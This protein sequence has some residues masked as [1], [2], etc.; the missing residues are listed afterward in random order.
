MKWYFLNTKARLRFALRYP[1]YVLR[2]TARE[3]TFADERFLAALTGNHAAQIR[4]FLHEPFN[5]PSFLAHLRD[6]E[7]V[8]RQ[9]MVSADLWAKKVLI[10]YAA[11]RALR[12]EILVETGVPSGVSSTYL[13]LAL[14]RNKKGTLH[15][16]EIGDP[17]YLPAGTSPG[18]I[19]PDW[20]R[21]RWRLHM[22]DVATVLPGLLRDLG[23]V[24]VFI[25]DSLHSYE[26]MKFEFELA[27]PFIKCGGLLIADDALWNPAFVEFAE[28]VSSPASRI[29]HGVGL[30][31]K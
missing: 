18:W 11:V 25:H 19:V 26:H 7:A 17:A 4:R 29:I 8:F 3:L 9:G 5:T 28:V 16:V 24:D 13:L 31:K 1:S 21:T 10:Q 23:E 15:S 14:E 12:P 30:M 27:V 20:L 6:C 2:A 22:G